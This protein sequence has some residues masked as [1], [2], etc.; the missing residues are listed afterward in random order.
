VG[1]RTLPAPGG[2]LASARVQDERA[3]K[4]LSQM[5]RK[6]TISVLVPGLLSQ[7]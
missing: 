6:D 3:E 4:A 2:R 5:S 1:G 7:M